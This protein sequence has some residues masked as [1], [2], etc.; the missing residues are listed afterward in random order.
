MTAHFDGIC[1]P[2]FSLKTATSGGIGEYLDLIPL[3]DW[4]KARGLNLIQI[5]PINDS[6]L[7]PSPYNLQSAFAL[8]PL[9]IKWPGL[10][11]QGLNELSHID[12]P[13]VRELKKNE[14]K[15]CQIPPEELN[16]FINDHP[17]VIEYAANKEGEK[18]L[19]E[20]YLCYSQLKAVKAHAD[21]QGITLMGDVPIL[22]AQD[23]LDVKLHPELFI[24]SLSAGA[25]P[26]NFNEAGQD[27]GFP[28]YDWEAAEK[29]HFTWW[30][31][32]LKWAE[33]FYH[34]Y[35]ID[36][37]VGFYR[38]W[39]TYYRG[40]IREGAFFPADKKKWIP[41][42][43][44]ILTTLMQ[45]TS[46]RPIGEDLGVVP[47]QIRASIQ[48]LGIPGTKVMRWERR[49]DEDGGFIPFSEYPE[50]SLTTVSTHDSEPL[51]LWWETCPEE[52]KEW[53]AFQGWIPT[54]TLSN[55]QLIEILKESHQTPSRYHVNQL[56]EYLSAVDGLHFN[57]T[58]WDRI[59]RP[60]TLSDHNWAW[61]M[62]PTIE[63]L[64]AS[65][66]LSKIFGY[67]LSGKSV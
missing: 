57:N 46:M 4:A 11:A 34:H 40:A 15:K 44:K 27:W 65:E 9:L 61:R 32:R 53:A 49:W 55:Q 56:V 52:A 36:H 25:P 8:N 51:R 21:S 35:R 67:C 54:P 59:N 47:T 66:P 22:V 48:R 38:I 50:L 5:L 18:S 37:I 26:D 41:Q 39:A 43:E 24:T 13:A 14:I 28:L 10:D 33:E 31:A 12:Y 63:E 23:S 3:I 7:D 20:Q 58:D 6:G 45:A 64:G 30:K 29:N 2:V 42:G 62:K 16:K 17:W 60:G 19:L 1:V